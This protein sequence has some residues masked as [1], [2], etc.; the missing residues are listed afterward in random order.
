MSVILTNKTLNVKNSEGNF[1][2]VAVATSISEA[3]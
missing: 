3:K 1:E 2:D